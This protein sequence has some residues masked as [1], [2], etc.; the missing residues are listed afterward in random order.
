[1]FPALNQEVITFLKEMKKLIFP[2]LSDPDPLH[3]LLLTKPAREKD[4]FGPHSAPTKLTWIG[5]A[6][7][8]FSNFLILSCFMRPL[9]AEY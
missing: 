1:M 9:D 8:S 4:M 3:Y 7:I 2:R 6:R 5:Q